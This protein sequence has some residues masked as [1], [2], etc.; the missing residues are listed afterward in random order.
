VVS[1][2]PE[3]APPRSLIELDFW[4]PKQVAEWLGDDPRWGQLSYIVVDELEQGVAGLVASP[5]PR[6]DERGRLHFGDEEDTY[7]VTVTEKD[8]LA[9][10]EERRL[11]IVEMKLDDSEKEELK[12][13]ELAIGDVFVARVRGRGG[14]PPGGDG[15]DGGT[16]VDPDKWIRGEVLD[17]TAE[18]REVAKVQTAA[19]IAGVVGDDYFKLVGEEFQDEDQ[20]PPDHTTDGKPSSTT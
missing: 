19:A 14:R 10:L 8:F 1:W 9:L 3:E 4:Q 17:I 16:P 5:W 20:G 12:A 2:L 7:D 11:P 13:R 15:P 18:A 6:I